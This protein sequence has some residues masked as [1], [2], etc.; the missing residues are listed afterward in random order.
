YGIR[1][2]RDVRT[3]HR[4]VGQPADEQPV[5]VS[6]MD[7][8][9]PLS[10]GADRSTETNSHEDLQSRKRSAAGSPVAADHKAGPQNYPSLRW[11]RARLEGLLPG[12][13]DEWSHAVA[14]R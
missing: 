7:P 3:L 1:R 13:P 12:P 9:H 6:L 14:G 5:H 11:Q 2:C 4:R 10:A 8:A